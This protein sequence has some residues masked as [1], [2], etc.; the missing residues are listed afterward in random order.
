MLLLLYIDIY[1]GDNGITFVYVTEHGLC[2]PIKN[3]IY[4]AKIMPH[5]HTGSCRPTITNCYKSTVQFYVDNNILS[6]EKF[7]SLCLKI[8]KFSFKNLKVYKYVYNFV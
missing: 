5:F 6:C 7:P 4:L 1:L 3:D 8:R 2:T